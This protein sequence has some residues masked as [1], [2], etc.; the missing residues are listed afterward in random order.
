[1]CYLQVIATLHQWVLAVL[2]TREREAELRM[3]EADTAL[4]A[5]LDTDGDGT[6]RHRGCMR[7]PP[8]PH[9][10]MVRH[11]RAGPHDRAC[12][13][14]YST[15]ACTHALRARMPSQVCLSEFIHL[16]DVIGLSKAVLRAR[17]REKVPSGANHRV[18]TDPSAFRAQFT[19]VCA[20]DI[21][22]LRVCC[23]TGRA[24][25]GSRP[26]QRHTLMS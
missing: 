6:V 10:F 12:T 16:D 25:D 8:T 23:R 9:A 2:A 11:R 18:P 3:R 5:R 15:A 24:R 1:M 14:P 22:A 17:F 13:H 4:I 7:A 20:T 26:T 19:T 21:A